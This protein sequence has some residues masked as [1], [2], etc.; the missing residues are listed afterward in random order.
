MTRSSANPLVII[1]T[2]DEVENI[3]PLLEQVLEALPEAHVLVVDDAS[4]DG[5][6]ARVDTMASRDPRIHLLERSGKLGLGTAYLAGF[7]WALQRDYS[8]VFEMDADFSHDPA[9]LRPMLEAAAHADVVIGS[10]YVDGGGTVD[11][12]WP[13]R[14]LSR[15][16]GLY[17]RSIL[18]M[19]VRDMT[20]GFKCYRRAA[21]EVV[22]L[23]E[24]SS[25]GYAF[26]IEM[27]YRAHLAGLR[28][29]E[30]PITFP[31]RARGT[32]K[33]SAA[34]AHEAMLQVV[35][36]RLRLGSAR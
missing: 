14:A 19:P 34:I 2:Y 10:R 3:G 35:R 4:P 1:P 6:A 30:T 31:D 7:R 15:F 18:G 28:L 29:V 26:Q 25:T 8:H 12:S 32:S 5:T 27:K 16:G 11:W 9:S 36:L 17:S 23:D 22:D 13:R 33:M 21:L 24:V 20:S